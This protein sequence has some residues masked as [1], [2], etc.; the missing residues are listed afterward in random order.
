MAR[1]YE[2]AFELG[3]KIA[4]SF[5]KNMLSAAGSLGALNSRIG[6]L[7][8]QAGDLSS[9]A[10]LRNQVGETSRAY[11]QAHTKVTELARGIAQTKNPSREMTNEF[12]RAKREAS[13]LKDRL[14]QQRTELTNLNRTMGTTGQSTATV[15]KRQQEMAR[16]AEQAQK[17]QASLQKT[18]RQIDQNK[19]NRANL[20][21][22]MLDAAALAYAMGRPV[23]VA[24]DF[25]QAMA[26]VAAVSN[27]TDEQLAELTKTARH[28][29][30]TTVF[31]ASQAAEGMQYLAMAGFDTERI[32]SAMPGVLGLAEAAGADLGRTSDIASDI[33]SGFGIEAEQMGRVSDVLAKAM[34]S[35]NTT[36]ETLGDTM[37]YVGPIAREAGMGLEEAAAMAG[38]LGNVGIKGSEAGTA[39]RAML[40]RLAAPTG[41]AADTL[42]G[43][44]IE[45]TDLDGNVRNMV[46]L[47][48]EMAQATE[49]MG[50]GERLAVL[51]DIFGERPAA[52]L[53]ELMAQEGAGGITKYLEVIN[54]ADGAVEAMSERMRNTASGSM[55]QLASA[56]EA[57]QISIGTLLIPAMQ[58][59][60]KFLTS[61]ALKVQAFTEKFPNLSKW[62][63]LITAGLVTLKVAAIAGGYAFTFVR[64][65]WLSAVL[66]AKTLNVWLTLMRTNTLRM[67]ASQKAAA[68]GTKIMTAAQWL[69]NSALLANP[70]GIVIGAIAAL[71]AA[72]VMLYKYWDYVA[73][74]F[75]GMWSGLVEG[76]APVKASFAALAPIMGLL[77]PVINVISKAFSWLIGLFRKTEASSESLEA[78]GQYGKSF[79]NLIAMG[80]NLATF[81][82]RGLIK[83]I[84]W[85]IDGAAKMPDL[86]SEGFNRMKDFVSNINLFE[87][88][89]A[90]L[91]TLTDGIKA[92]AMAPINAVKGVFS[93]VRDL[94]PFSD[95]K[96]GPLSQLTSSGSAIMETLGDG[97]QDAP[98]SAFASKISEKLAQVTG[99]FGDGIKKVFGA[100]LDG[101]RSLKSKFTEPVQADATGGGDGGIIL[102]YSPTIHVDGGSNV[103][104]QVSDAT[105]AGADDL[106]SRL[107]E[108]SNRERRLSYD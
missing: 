56:T 46:E 30:A 71:I 101:I 21:G 103:A 97:V 50:S 78:A 80:I 66:A 26:R 65:A 4:G 58:A 36:L 92:M 47:M 74:F 40:L 85:L 62:L 82:I 9:L 54:N 31:T 11:T 1:V 3:A 34:T 106:M 53:A 99:V 72:G 28:L 8:R 90:I 12:E 94:L 73:S 108:I 16:A 23:K 89:K 18:M 15:T 20:R 86:I 22:Q 27:S 25:E 83:L 60:T 19:Q 107:R 29:G 38:L 33:L 96:I 95:A 17:A 67:A 69:L 59:A 10:K 41:A 77:E 52:A 68:A 76:M 49:Q 6:D 79:G 61:V 64:G 88:G 100:P 75:K 102:H 7:N 24:A 84:G 39:M 55:K 51:K 91:S 70:I 93:K 63:V 35:S 44:G 45:V 104:Q 42:A 14:T 2:I 98:Q 48:G 105:K 87:A 13:Q 43:L 32:M 81:P 57:V 5:D 37:K